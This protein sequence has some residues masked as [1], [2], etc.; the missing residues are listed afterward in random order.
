VRS[1]VIGVANPR[2][3]DAPDSVSDLHEIARAGQTDSAYLV[4]TGS[5]DATVQA[6]AAAV[7]SIREASASCAV[8][9]PEPAGGQAFDRQKVAVSYRSRGAQ[10]E[11]G[12]DA[13]CMRA[14][15]WR[16]DDP[17][18][19]TQIELCPSSCDEVKADPEADL[20]IL[21]ACDDL[22]LL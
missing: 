22:I 13:S 21:F 19:P 20:E 8:A 14:R 9:I 10:V 11:L 15:S 4:D 3:E 18:A 5:P 1:Y 16:Y 2:I 12:Y 7:Q 17:E 6:F